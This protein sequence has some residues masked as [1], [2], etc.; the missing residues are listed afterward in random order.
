MG[1]LSDFPRLSCARLR[2]CL[3]RGLDVG[4]CVGLVD[5]PRGGTGQTYLG[6]KQLEEEG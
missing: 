1:G 4:K 2:R 5:L 6:H 3:G